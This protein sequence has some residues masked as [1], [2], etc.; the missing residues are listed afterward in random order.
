MNTWK[1]IALLFAASIVLAGCGKSQTEATND[2]IEK[3]EAAC[4]A[5]DP[6]KALEIA[7]QF[8]VAELTPEQSVRIIKASNVGAKA[9]AD[10]FKGVTNTMPFNHWDIVLNE[11]E[12]LI[13]QYADVLKLKRGGNKKAKDQLDKLDDKIDAKKDVL[14][15]AKLTK[16]QQSRFKKLAKWYDDIED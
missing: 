15:D 13:K 1:G 7:K 2:V 14:D 9:A 11:Y 4:Q 5:G 8:D 16:A 6:V 3:Y 10:A 12:D